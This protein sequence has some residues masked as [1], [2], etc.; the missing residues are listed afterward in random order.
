MASFLEK[1]RMDKIYPQVFKPRTIEEPGFR[2]RGLDLIGQQPQS[3][4]QNALERI[5]LQ[6]AGLGLQ[7]NKMNLEKAQT[8][9]VVYDQRPEMFNKELQLQKDKMR[10]QEQAGESELALAERALTDQWQQQQRENALRSKQIDTTAG[11]KEAELGLKGAKLNLEAMKAA[12]FKEMGTKGGNVMMYNPL[13][14]Q[15]IDTGVSS[16]ELT[17]EAGITKRG[18][19]TRE[20]ITHGADE[21]IRRDTARIENR[22]QL[23]QHEMAALKLRVNRLLSE[24]PE[25]ADYIELDEAGLPQVKSGEA[26]IFGF[27][28]V[29]PE[30]RQQ[31]MRGLYGPD[32]TKIQGPTSLTGVSMKGDTVTMYDPDGNELK[33]PKDKVKALE[34]QGASTTRQRK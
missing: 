16:G 24:H 13:T 7:Q 30:I 3:Q 31:I 9:D 29:S 27:G 23:P 20:N 25:W 5:G 17:E 2:G 14:G 12:G 18:E 11:Y 28:G 32:D 10:M 8:P 34:A 19:I 26:N 22:P 15:T 4:A 1:L 21:G 6:Q 33:V